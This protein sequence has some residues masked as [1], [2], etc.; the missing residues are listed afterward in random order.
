VSGNRQVASTTKKETAVSSIYQS[1][2]AGASAT[3][4][5]PE[6]VLVSLSEIA[7]SAREGLLALAVSAGLQVMSANAPGCAS[8]RVRGRSER[9]STSLSWSPPGS[10][11]SSPN[12][13]VTPR[14][15]SQSNTS[16]HH[17]VVTDDDAQE[18]W[19]TRPGQD[20]SYRAEFPTSAD[21]LFGSY[22]VDVMDNIL[23]VGKARRRLTI[24]CH[25]EDVIS[26]VAMTWRHDAG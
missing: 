13:V 20:R 7:E 16:R 14:Y 25:V 2:T 11:R 9:I 26:Y 3:P 19:A 23:A 10:S 22:R 1:R 6:Q 24:I 21:A 4:A 8:V 18:T 5:V 12:A 15:A 17:R